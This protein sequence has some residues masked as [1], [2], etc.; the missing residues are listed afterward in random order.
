MIDHCANPE[1]KEPLHYLRDGRIFVFE[2][3]GARI[4]ADGKRVRRTEHYWLCE[5][6]A[7]SMTL[8]YSPDR[9]LL[10]QDKAGISLAGTDAMAS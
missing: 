9:G 2:V 8:A 4:G 3:P 7:S 6:C 1:C 10:F 5:K